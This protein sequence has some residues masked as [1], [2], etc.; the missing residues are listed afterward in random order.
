MAAQVLRQ[1]NEGDFE[2]EVLRSE[3]PVAVDFF[4]DWCGPCRAVAPVIDSLSRD[5]AGRAKF[6]KVNV[7]ENEGLA[8]RYGVQSIP[9]IIVFKGGRVLDRVIGVAQAQLYRSKIDA[10]I[11]G[12]KA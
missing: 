6:V 12:G 1:L 10:A 3:I 4:A 5:Y 2:L 8:S 7:D 11:A 9:T